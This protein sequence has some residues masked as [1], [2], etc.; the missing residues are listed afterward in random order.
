VVVP[1]AFPEPREVGELPDS[2]RG[3]KGFGSSAH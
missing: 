3:E 1:V 2:E